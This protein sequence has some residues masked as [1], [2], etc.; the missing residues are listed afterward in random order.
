[1]RQSIIWGLCALGLALPASAAAQRQDEAPASQVLRDAYFT[2]SVAVGGALYH[3]TDELGQRKRRFDPDRDEKVVFLTV[4]DARSSVNVR[5]ELIRP[6]GQRQGVQ[7]PDQSQERWHMAGKVLVVG[8]ERSAP[9]S[10]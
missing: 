5:G 10:R 2:N 8:D 4:F 3:R 6:N 1:M 9:V 7:L